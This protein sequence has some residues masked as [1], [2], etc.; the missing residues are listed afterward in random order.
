MTALR[1]PVALFLLILVGELVSSLVLHG[2]DSLTPAAVGTATLV[3]ALI[4]V[5]WDFAVHRPARQ[6]MRMLRGRMRTLSA[7][8]PGAPD[9]QPRPG[10]DTD[11]LTLDR[12]LVAR[13]KKI[14]AYT[15]RLRSQL[16]RYQ[17]IYRQSHDAVLVFE[18]HTMVL[19]DCNPRAC[20]F[21]G[22][23]RGEMTGLRLVDLH[24]EDETYLR[25]L[26]DDVMG[27]THG[28]YFRI[29]YRTADGRLLPA[30]VSA[31]RIVHEQGN[32]LMCIARDVSERENAARK[33]QHLAYHDTLTNLPN[34]TLLTDRVNRALARAR[35][36]S[37]VG[38]LLFLDLD[39]FKRI[40]DSLGH[41]VG[42]ALLK[43]LANR[44]RA[45]LREEDTV[46][47][48][49]G[50]EFVILLEG[51]G[52]DSQLATDKASEIAEKVRQVFN[53]EFMLDGHELYVT[54]SIGIVTFP[55]DGDSVE[56]L[57]RHADTAMYHAKGAGRDGA[58]VFESRMDEAATSRLRLENELR[59]ALREQQFELYLQP[60]LAIRDGRVLGA[61]VLVRWQHPTEGLISPTEFMTYIENCSLMLK[62]DDWVLTETCRLLGEIEAD[63][64]LQVPVSLSVNVS[65]QQF[66]QADFVDRVA[67]ILQQT[68]AD[69]R[70]LQFDITET[71]LLKDTSESVARINALKK[72]GI[73]F[74]IDDFG[75][76]YSSLADLRQLPIDTIK[77]DRTFI[78]DIATDQNDAAI[79]RA[80]LSMA[81]HLGV[82]VIAEGVETREQL[83]FL[84]Q[85]GC[86]YYQGFLGRPP[87]SAERFREELQFSG[88]LYRPVSPEK[89][90][91]TEIEPAS[92]SSAA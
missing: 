4:A 79:V 7:R 69:P 6:G 1:K 43:E 50:D 61:E 47:R 65:Q 27:S 30:E 66:H 89:S 18:P 80:V 48:L 86:H 35:R 56:T 29:N 82:S 76:G 40:N 42:D 34:R 83:S 5:V 55:R 19:F 49:G 92:S 81:T 37:Q 25:N 74:A 14:A 46:A 44:L 52:T 72:M 67:M 21:L 38:A 63:E 8:A 91:A 90:N 62:L 53:D 71:V 59:I 85:A 84:R 3:A 32:L 77:I 73:R 64:D 15:R 9:D 20:D 10:S 78:R 24:D 51:L 68:S 36:T 16:D 54:S 17:A 39:R 12:I 22:R 41:S 11:P 57:L 58:R 26:I 23:S 33:I 28:R 45:T 60:V 70:R 88:E 31:S 75:T 87:F 13:Q 2:A